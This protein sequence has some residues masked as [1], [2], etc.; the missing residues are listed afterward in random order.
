MYE[1]MILGLLLRRPM[2]GYLIAKIINDA[3][4]PFKRVQWGA[5]YPL[6]ARL[7]QGGY[8]TAEESEACGD[9]RMR[10]VFHITEAGRERFYQLMLDTQ[11]HLADYDLVF[12]MKLAHFQF[13]EPQERL[14]LLRHYMVYAQ[15][16]IDFTTAEAAELVELH[17]HWEGAMAESLPYI[18]ETLHQK[19]RHWQLE[20]EWA[21]RLARREFR[22]L[23]AQVPLEH[24][25]IN[26]EQE[27]LE[28]WRRMA[29]WPTRTR[30]T[31]SETT[32]D[33]LPAQPDIQKE[34]Q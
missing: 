18:L 14:M 27:G 24:S 29:D 34:V 2:H 21:E 23:E 26:G 33:A 15:Q 30:R 32:S 19:V 10:K 16:V 20:L 12:H 1:L 25:A 22:T 28:L 5:L 9:G 13:L 7:K 3:M 8:I 31:H 11:H 6:L 17:K 4:G